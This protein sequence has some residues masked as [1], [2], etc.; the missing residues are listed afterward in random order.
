MKQASRL[1]SLLVLV[2]AFAVLAGSA[3]KK[4]PERAWTP[5][6]FQPV[7]TNIQTFTWPTGVTVDTLNGYEEDPDAQESNTPLYLVVSNSGSDVS[8]TLPAG[9]VFAPA[10]P[11]T[12]EYMMLVKPFTFTA[13]G[14]G[15]ST[16]ILPTYGCNEDS[17]DVPSAD[18]FYT[19]AGKEYDKE[20][21]VLLDVMAGKTI[22]G[23]DN[24]ELVQLGL[25]EI[26]EGPGLA[27][28]TKTALQNLQ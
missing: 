22:T 3:C 12:F 9:L 14:G 7:N 8:V 15:T 21:Q 18:C 26:T 27:D 28:S 19:V 11:T 23:D 10:D 4:I 24:K 1:L 16:A 17:A 6:A 5:G 20:T 25:T 13:T 2:A